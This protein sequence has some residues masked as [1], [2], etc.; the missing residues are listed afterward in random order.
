[1]QRRHV[2]VRAQ[3]A[4]HQVR[5]EQPAALPRPS[6]PPARRRAAAKA[7]GRE[8]VQVLPPEDG[9]HLLLRELASAQQRVAPVLSHPGGGDTP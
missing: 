3:D 7:Y 8:A 9:L 5:R 4:L 6:A 1:V 2:A